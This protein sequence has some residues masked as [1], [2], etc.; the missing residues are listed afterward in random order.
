[1]INVGMTIRDLK[2]GRL[3]GLMLTSFVSLN[4]MEVVLVSQ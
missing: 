3:N 4:L 1:M 2:D